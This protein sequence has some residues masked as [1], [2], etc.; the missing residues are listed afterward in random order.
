MRRLV[1]VVSAFWTQGNLDW[2]TGLP[3]PLDRLPDA[4]N[5]AGV[6]IV[7][8][9]AGWYATLKAA[10]SFGRAAPIVDRSALA[11][12]SIELA[13]ARLGSKNGS[14][15]RSKSPRRHDRYKGRKKKA[16]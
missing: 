1:V 3:C 7:C 16:E 11:N 14:R 6:L 8:A 10:E 5:L 15:S 2:Q 13:K 12:D 9:G 4:V